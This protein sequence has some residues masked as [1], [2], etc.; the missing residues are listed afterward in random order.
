MDI[1]SGLMCII[2]EK[3]IRLLPGGIVTFHVAYPGNRAISVI[4]NDARE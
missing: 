3:F 4:I 2:S 1:K